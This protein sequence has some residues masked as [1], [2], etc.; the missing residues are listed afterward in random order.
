M[1]VALATAMWIKR[2]MKRLGSCYEV[3]VR[4][5]MA[6]L[7]SF[8]GT[9]VYKAGCRRSSEKMLGFLQATNQ[10]HQMQNLFSRYYKSVLVTKDHLKQCL[11]NRKEHSMILQRL[12]TRERGRLAEELLKAGASAPHKKLGALLAAVE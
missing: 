6:K 9:M 1:W 10:K 12:L 2:Y 4:R 8:G 5:N 11:R 3:R 7:L